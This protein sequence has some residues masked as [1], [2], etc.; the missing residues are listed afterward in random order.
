MESRG[1]EQR[2][3]EKGGYMLALVGGGRLAVEFYGKGYTV[4][5]YT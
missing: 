1:D 2:G 5:L 3:E 4:L